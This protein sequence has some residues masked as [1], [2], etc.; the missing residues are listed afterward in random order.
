VSTPARPALAVDQSFPTPVLHALAR[1]LPE[2]ELVPLRR[3]DNRMAAL[4][5]RELVIALGQ[6]GWPGLVT[7]NHKLVR[8]ASTVAALLATD[9]AAI[10]V[11]GVGDDPLRATGA[12]LLALPGA[13]LALGPGRPRIVQV[14]GGV[15]GRAHTGELF[16]RLAARQRRDPDELLAELGVAADEL[17]VPVLPAR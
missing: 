12:L 17:A 7:A 4:G 10:V 16:A 11:E 15:I 5:D 14:R 6:A 2:V 3:I 1:F 9:L 8:S 13:M